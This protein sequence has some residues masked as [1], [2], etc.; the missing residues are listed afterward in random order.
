METP[1]DQ[2]TSNQ[3][4]IYVTKQNKKLMPKKCQFASQFVEVLEK[5][6]SVKK[7]Q[8]RMDKS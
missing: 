5:E 8:R 1:D 6:Q 7:V 2:K 3:V 4:R